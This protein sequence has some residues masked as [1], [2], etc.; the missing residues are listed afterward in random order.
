MVAG[1][2]KSRVPT[3][4]Q[5]VPLRDVHKLRPWGTERLLRRLVF[6]RRL[7]FHKIGG[8]VF[9]ALDDLDAFAESG[10]VEAVP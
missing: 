7:P 2:T 5:L 9:I 1:P 6:E 3:A 10:R 4:R 8:R